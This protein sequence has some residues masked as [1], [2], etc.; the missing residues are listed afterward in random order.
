M[1]IKKEYSVLF[2]AISDAIEELEMALNKGETC[3]KILKDA[4][5]Q[6]EEMYI[7]KNDCENE[8]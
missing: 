5:R 3:L 4:Q 7:N 6:T 8:E 1:E 2:N